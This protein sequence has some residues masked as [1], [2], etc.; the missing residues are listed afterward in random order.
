MKCEINLFDCLFICNTF[1][2]PPSSWSRENFFPLS[3]VRKFFTIMMTFLN[4]ESQ[5]SRRSNHR[6]RCDVHFDLLLR[7]FSADIS[8]AVD[9]AHTQKSSMLTQFSF[10]M[11]IFWWRFVPY[12][13]AFFL[14]LWN[15][16][17]QI[18]LEFNKWENAAE[19]LTLRAFFCKYFNSS[20]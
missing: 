15:A 18:Y 20:S 7:S 1:K 3:F 9:E 10:A 8:N 16:S 19:N 2:S 11:K 14:D 5:P 6:L 17:S 12:G 13:S 4:R